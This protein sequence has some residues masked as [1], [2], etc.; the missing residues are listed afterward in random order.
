MPTTLQAT[1][2]FPKALTLGA[3]TGDRVDCG[4]ASDISGFT[5]FSGAALLFPTTLTTPRQV[6]SK[7]GAS[8]GWNIELSDANGNVDIFF[9]G[10]TALNYITNS[11]PLRLNTWRFLAWTCD[12][13]LGAGQKV[14][15]YSSTAPTTPLLE[16]TYG[17]QTEG[18]TP[19]ADTTSDPLRW[20]NETSLTLAFQGRMALGWYAPGTA[21]SLQDL[22]RWQR[23]PFRLLTGMKVFTVFDKETG[24]LVDRTGLGHN[25]T[26]T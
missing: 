14:H 15:F 17:T 3:A 5:K 8:D 9:A 4:G 19:A 1:F 13:S 12:T 2:G 26:V 6:C 11:T 22:Q 21:Y 20:G 10:V 23:E 7:N 25:G 18:A 16:A 24:L